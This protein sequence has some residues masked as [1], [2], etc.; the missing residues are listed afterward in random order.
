MMCM[1]SRT[2]FDLDDDNEV[3]CW[4]QSEKFL[5]RCFCTHGLRKQHGPSGAATQFIYKLCPRYKCDPH[6]KCRK[7]QAIQVRN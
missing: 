7:Y 5:N 1:I 3:R 4:E 6:R 2:A